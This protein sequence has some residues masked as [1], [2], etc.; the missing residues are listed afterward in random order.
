M[1]DPVEPEAPQPDSMHGATADSGADAPPAAEAAEA[2][3]AAPDSAAPDAATAVAKPKRRNPFYLR[4]RRPRL[5]SS[6]RGL[7]A[8]LLV[9]GGLGFVSV[10]SAVS[11]I[12]WTET[13]D[14]CGR[15]H[16][17]APELQAYEA[18]PHKSVACAEC[19][20]EP[21][22]LGWIKAKINGTKQLI[23]VVLGTYPT[24]IP[25]PDHS[26]MPP[27]SETCEGCHG[28]TRQAVNTL[29]TETVYTEDEA[30]T[31]QFVALMIRPSGG[32]PFDVSSSV[33][34]HVL[35]NVE[36]YSS[37]PK[38]Q[39]IDVVD[40]TQPDGS[41]ATYVAQSK[42]K[43]AGNVT[44]DLNAVRTSEIK[45]TMSCYDCHN[46]AGHDIANPRTGLDQAMQSGTIDPTLPYIKHEGMQ[47][48]WNS[49]P[50]TT[51]ADAAADGLQQ[52]YATNYPQ[53]AAD[54]VQQID[55]AI[56]EIKVLYRLTA[57][58]EMKVTAQTYP[59]NL[60]HLD[61]PGCF[62]CHDGGHYKVVNGVATKEVIPSTCDTCHTFPQIGPAVASLP[63]GQPPTTHSDKL[64]VFNHKNVATSVDPGGQSCGNCHA[65]D[66]C[67]NCHSTG[68]ITVNHDEMA[69]N[70]AAVIRKQGNT[71]CAYCHQP[72]FCATCH[73]SQQMLP[74]TT[75]FS[76]KPQQPASPAPSSIP[77]DVPLPGS[78]APATTGL[79]FPLRGSPGG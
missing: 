38:A 75:P 5:P 19:H 12:H 77:G 1:S 7:F 23:D 3:A 25:P 2:D 14:F 16:T 55:S 9:L 28:V 11:L 32:D 41:V 61:F 76:S 20:V 40:A 51:A 47:I 31:P 46:R 74:E 62:R 45:T 29:K 13:A 37:D 21:G 65:K 6:R 4:G 70:H 67:V 59:N 69:T 60:G 15:C 68:A 42:I 56:A 57:T 71:A 18:G 49:Y 72:V 44:P 34:W 50:D 63:M 58:P 53:V 24:P 10:F 22:I 79:V 52:Y 36:F 17:M 33:H 43:D 39:T 73:G 48:L 30:N 27:A 8:L 78:S 66:Y 54:K 35:R 26:D 64:W